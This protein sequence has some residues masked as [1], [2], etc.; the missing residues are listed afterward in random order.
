[1][2][3]GTKLYQQIQPILSKNQP[4]E[5]DFNQVE[6]YAS[7]FFNASVGLLLKDISIE[8]L[9]RLMKIEHINDVGKD[10]LNHVIDNALEYY[11]KGNNDKITS[12]LN[13]H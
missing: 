8:E 12:A 4:I 10:L 2:S 5:L 6:L 9:L 1:M 3:S 7:P 13:K 11:A